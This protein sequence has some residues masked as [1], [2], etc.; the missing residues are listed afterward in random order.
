MRKGNRKTDKTQEA[1]TGMETG[2]NEKAEV[3]KN[4]I[5][6]IYH[7]KKIINLKKIRTKNKT[8]TMRMKIDNSRMDNK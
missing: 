7:K 3:E 6:I 2:E 1:I 4:K 5:K 8:T